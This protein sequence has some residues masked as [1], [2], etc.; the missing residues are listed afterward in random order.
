VEEAAAGAAAIGLHRGMGHHSHV[1]VPIH[2]RV[3]AAFQAQIVTQL[4]VMGHL[5]HAH[6]HTLARMVVV[7]LERHAAQGVAQEL[8]VHVA[9]PVGVT[10]FQVPLVHVHKVH[11]PITHAQTAGPFP[12]PPVR[13]H[14]RALRSMDAPMGGHLVVES[15]RCPMGSVCAG[16][17]CEGR[18]F[19]V[20][21]YFRPKRG[22]LPK[23]RRW[24]AS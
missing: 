11:T 20:S 17:F 18:W 14:R 16:A 24:W 10:L 13:Y 3:E 7:F 19:E 9:I 8:R 21:A 5:R 12:D 15:V 4:A 22:S 1:P 23:N 6:A 2:A